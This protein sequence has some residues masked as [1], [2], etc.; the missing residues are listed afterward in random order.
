MREPTGNLRE[1]HGFA[2]RASRTAAAYAR[3]T[4]RVYAVALAAGVFLA[5]TDAFG[6][7]APLWRRLL[8][9]PAM[10]LAGAA[11]GNTVGS[12]A[13]RRPR[14]GEN[15][16][17]LW[18][19]ITLLVSAATTPL[20]WA[21]TAAMYRRGFHWVD[22]PYFFGTVLLISAPMTA[23]VMMLNTP[24]LATHASPPGA[25][26][27]KVRFLERLP[28]KI[29]G[30]AIWAVEA[31]DHY[32]RVRTS[33]G[34]DLILMR[35]ADAIVELEGIEGAQVHRSWWVARAGIAEVK[36][37]GARVT[38]MLKDGAEAPVSRPNVKALR[39]AG[40]F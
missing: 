22:L 36:R 30:G 26:P 2:A 13:G 3:A 9:W 12:L 38:M 17:L 34:S 27:A 20:V 1:P 23:I 11:I 31:E 37:D 5:L 16:V 14:L 35:L 10:L 7:D 25:A 32:L 28:P 24:G 29:M 15:R 21:I 8:Y 18:A 33:K 39:E 6:G 4:W 19:T 40:W